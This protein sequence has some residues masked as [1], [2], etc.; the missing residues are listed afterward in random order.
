MDF[1]PTSDQ[2]SLVEAIDKV[3]TQ[4]DRKSVV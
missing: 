3:A 2:E 1:R 4:L